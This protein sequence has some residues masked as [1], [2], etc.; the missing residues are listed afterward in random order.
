MWKS[1][2]D[3]LDAAGLIERFLQSKSLYPQEWNDF[4]DTP[5]K[6]TE[7]EIIR[8]RCFELDPLINRPGTS[9]PVALAE[10]ES[11]VSALRTKR[12]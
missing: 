3:S 10:L 2:M 4:V 1:D 6:R 7:V 5:Q 9:D 8:R 12:D 11:V